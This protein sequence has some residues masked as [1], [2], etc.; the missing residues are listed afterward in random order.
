[1]LFDNKER[2]SYY[3]KL[4]LINFFS[5]KVL[6]VCVSAWVAESFLRNVFSMFK[7]KDNQSKNGLQ[8]DFCRVRG[9]MARP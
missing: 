1:M 5:E 3:P 2:K 4:R 6:R 8:M 9:G 7:D